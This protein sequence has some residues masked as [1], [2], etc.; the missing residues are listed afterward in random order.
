MQQREINVEDIILCLTNFASDS[1]FGTS[2]N[3]VKED[4]LINLNDI[5]L[6]KEN[7]SFKVLEPFNCE[8]LVKFICYGITMVPLV[9]CCNI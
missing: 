1:K 5:K 3:K 8:K 4:N 6:M 9:G 2:T 7:E